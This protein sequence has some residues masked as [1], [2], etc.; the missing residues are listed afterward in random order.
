[1]AVREAIIKT[2]KQAGNGPKPQRGQ[3]VTVECTG[4]VKATSTKFWSTKDPGQKPF[5]FNVGLGQVIKGWDEGVL[6]MALGEEADLDC[7]SDYA[8]GDAG[9]P[10]WGIP[11]KA[12]LI[13]TIKVLSIQ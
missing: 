9:F 8:Y 6:G 5:S 13:F 10:A 1:M 7:R 11:P 12:D 2:L 4:V 3:K